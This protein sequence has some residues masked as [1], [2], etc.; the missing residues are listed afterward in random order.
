V[1]LQALRPTEH[2]P[3]GPQLAIV[4]ESPDIELVPLPAKREETAGT[5]SDSSTRMV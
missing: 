4:E 2:L 1:L 5:V 3:P